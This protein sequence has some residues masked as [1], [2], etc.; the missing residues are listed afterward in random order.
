MT[1]SEMGV[2]AR[3]CERKGKEENERIK[4]SKETLPSWPSP[5]R[6]RS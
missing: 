2:S 6:G 4:A 5:N 1:S 3:V